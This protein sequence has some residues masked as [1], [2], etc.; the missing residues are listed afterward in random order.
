MCELERGKEG[1]RE[2]ENK[3]DKEREKQRETTWERG[4]ECVR[5]RTSE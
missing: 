4:G 1:W 2:G 3:N 5:V